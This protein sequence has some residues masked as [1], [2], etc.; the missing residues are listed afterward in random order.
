MEEPLAPGPAQAAA[1]ARV[2]GYWSY[3]HF[4]LPLPARH[5]YPRARF[6]VVRERLLAEG[7]LLPGHVRPAAPVPWAL[8]ERVHDADYLRAVR[9]G[10]LSP[11]AVRE[12]GLPFSP[13]LVERARAAVGATCAAAWHAL[14]AG[15]GCVIGG[16]TH[17][18]FVERGAGYCLF[19][20]IAVAIR[21]LQG[22]HAVHRVAIVDLDVHQGNGNAEI[23]QHDRDVFTFSVHGAHNWP[24]RKSVGDF[25]LGLPD[26]TGDA[27]YLAA[28]EPPLRE[29]LERF[30]PDA[31]F[32]LA[33]A[34]PLHSDRLGRLALTHAGLRARD[35][36]VLGLCA[37]Q[38]L[39]VVVTMGGGYAVPPE[40]TILAHLHTVHALQ[41]IYGGG[42]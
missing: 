26:G 14:E 7:T 41:A 29:L 25:D 16:G 5:R 24:H 32:Y 6:Q 38:G 9:D 37:E 19:S 8:L 39:P 17:H 33:G 21:D 34:D 22:R 40:D 18:A 13:A 4:A 42:L 11:R 1:G 23:F 35:R 30:R 12:I 20:D 2:P 15:A 28:L 36:L 27:A 10:T 31:V 3:D